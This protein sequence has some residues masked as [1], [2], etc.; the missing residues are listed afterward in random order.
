MRGGTD[1]SEESRRV[2]PG[3]VV[4]TGRVARV[5]SGLSSLTSFGVLS[6]GC[7]SSRPTGRWGSSVVLAGVASSFVAYASLGAEVA[8]TIASLSGRLLLPGILVASRASYRS[9]SARRAARAR[10]GQTRTQQPQ[11]ITKGGPPAA[12]TRLAPPA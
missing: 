8:T 5:P 12:P 11:P 6:S 1:F 3:A 2:V 4:T 9:A 7:W 10:P